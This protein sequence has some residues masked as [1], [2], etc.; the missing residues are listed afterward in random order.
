MATKKEKKEN[1]KTLKLSNLSYSIGD[2]LI[3]LNNAAKAKKKEVVLP[4]TKLILSV[5][6][7]LEKAG[8][9]E[10]VQKEGEILSL[11]LRYSHKEPIL[12][13]VRLISKPGLR[14][15]KDAKELEKKRGAS[16]LIISSSKGILTHREAI[17]Q[18]TGG[19]VIAEIS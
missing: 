12:T 13:K 2:F 3:R 6:Q 5:A 18:R 7:S 15:Y 9:I 8:F 1:Q 14:V 10:K 4:S 11:N 19:E 16:I 17:K